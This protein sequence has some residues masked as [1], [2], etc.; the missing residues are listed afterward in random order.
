[1][2]TTFGYPFGNRVLEAAGFAVSFLVYSEDNVFTPDPGRLKVDVR[3]DGVVI[4]A[5]RFAFAGLQQQAPGSFTARIRH[6]EGGMDCDISATME[7]RIK[8][9]TLLLQD[10]PIHSVPT[11]DYADTPATGLV[12][13]RYPNAL[14]LPVF[15]LKHEDGSIL[16]LTSLDQRVRGKVIAITHHDGRALIEAHHH[17]DA[18]QWSGRQQTPTWRVTRGGVEA[19]FAQ[20]ARIAEQAWGLQP[21]DTRSDV[22]DWMRQI[23]LVLNLHGM[24]WTGYLFNNYEQQLEA[25]RYVASK[26]E[27][28]RVLAYLAAWDGRYNYNWP[29]YDACEAMG[30]RAGLTRLVAEAHKLG[31]HVIPQIGAVSANRRFLPPALHDSASQDAYGNTYVKDICWDNDRAGD[32]YRVNANIGHPGFRSFLL[33]QAFA[34][35]DRFGF[36]GMFLDINMQFHNDPRFSIVE[37]HRAF[38][39]ACHDRYRDYLVFGENWYDGLMPMYPLVHSVTDEERGLMAKWADAFDRYC[40]TTYHLIHPA[41]CGSTGVYEAGYMKPWVPDPNRNA[42]PAIG[43]AKD[44][45]ANHRT[46]VDQ[47]IEAAKAYIRRMGL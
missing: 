42:I 7:E 46:E 5:D 45:L 22:P 1:M 9:T 23:G 4:T 21:W 38:A 2:S 44:T 12:T 43:F 14:R 25:I 29:A 15:P 24:H 6:I 41:P 37:G 20:R 36:D 34:I 31:V 18:R 10:R 32:T 19:A 33:D 27:G 13:L 11:R 39:A 3:P 26:I 47:R 17:E 35:T 30:G 8:G 40:R 28:R 16:T